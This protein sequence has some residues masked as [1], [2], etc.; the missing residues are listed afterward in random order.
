MHLEDRRKGLIKPRSKNDF[1]TN[2]IN[3]TS[4]MLYAV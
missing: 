4:L 2:N 1:T 3:Y